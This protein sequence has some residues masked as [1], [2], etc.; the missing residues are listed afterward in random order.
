MDDYVFVFDNTPYSEQQ[1]DFMT[2]SMGLKNHNTV[3]M[4]VQKQY[5]KTNPSYNPS[6]DD[7]TTDATKKI[8]HKAEQIIED[9]TSTDPVEIPPMTEDDSDIDVTPNVD[10]II[11]TGNDDVDPE[12]KDPTPPKFDD[13]APPAP[14]LSLEYAYYLW[15]QVGNVFSFFTSTLGMVSSFYH[16]ILG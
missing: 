14:G 2:I 5:R 13:S 16:K 12:F 8:E 6:N 4:E 3:Q 1:K 15:T 11:K 10:P 9:E 7:T